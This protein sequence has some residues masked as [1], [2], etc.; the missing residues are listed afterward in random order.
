MR[1][2]F[3]IACGVLGLLAAWP[4][5]AAE[6]SF[7]PEVLPVELKVGYAVSAVDLS[8]DG[9]L[10]IAIVDSK[11]FIWLENPSWQV[12]V[13]H[14]EP[15]AA[16]DN[17]CFAP[18]DIDGDGD[19]DFAVGRDW[20]P[21]NSDSGGHVGWLEC[22]GDPR[23]T[24]TYREILQEPTVH[25]MR[26]VD[27]QGDDEPELVV[28]PLKG[29]GSRGPGFD[30]TPIRL[31]KLTP[32]GSGEGEWSS[33]V[34]LDSLHVC[35]NIDVVDFD[36][37]GREGLLA[38]SFEGVTRIWPDGSQVRTHRLG[39]GD[40]GRPPAAGSSEVRLGHTSGDRYIAT[41]EPWHGDQVVVYTPPAE[42]S[43]LWDR[44]VLDRELKWGHAVSCV[45]LD[46]DPD[47]E[48]VIGVRDE[49]SAAHRS[50]VRIYDPVDAA[51]G[52]WQRRLIEPGQVAVED[53]T[54]ADL[55]GD[56]DADIIAVGRATHN[57]VIYWN[58]L[59]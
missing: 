39:S 59:K 25:R 1:R 12:H 21:G 44:H 22:P 38:A 20:Q 51:S 37:D 6:P 10:D 17:V 53:L 33:E 34:L 18:H 56:G 45:D 50:G 55:D 35:H 2:E 11:R 46:G 27:W 48:L 47:Q 41:I 32:P 24:W 30:N 49:A 16:N 54:T 57:A 4:A 26:W 7:E 19:I 29:R 43:R 23:H 52:Q 36:G 3:Q 31:L 28:A 13:M 42:A 15:G 8:G 5:V 14:A 9:K 40:P 58:G